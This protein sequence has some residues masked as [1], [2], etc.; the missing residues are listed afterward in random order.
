MIYTFPNDASAFPWIWRITLEEAALTPSP[1]SDEGALISYCCVVVVNGSS[2]GV[3]WGINGRGPSKKEE[4]FWQPQ[5]L[6]YRK[7]RR[8]YESRRHTKIHIRVNMWLNRYVLSG[9]CQPASA[10]TRSQRLWWA[11][12]SIIL[13][14]TQHLP[15]ESIHSGNRVTPLQGGKSHNNNNNN[16]W[17]S[18]ND[19]PGNAAPS[20]GGL[21]RNGFAASILIMAN[22][23]SVIPFPPTRLLPQNQI[24]NC[25]FSLKEKFIHPPHPISTYL[26]MLIFG[27]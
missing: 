8:A 5:C 20:S 6:E 2:L 16:N 17:L 7:Y 25:Q 15:L 1:P 24:Y 9:A 26:H 18:L 22:F 14:S 3:G 10:S 11:L 23:R 13:R 27:M 4:I 21:S 19:T 12:C